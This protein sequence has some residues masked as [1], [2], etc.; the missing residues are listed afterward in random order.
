[1]LVGSITFTQFLADL[2][3]VAGRHLAV[4]HHA[5]ERRAHLGALQLLAREHDAGLGAPRG[6]SARCC[7]APRR[8]RAAWAEV[9]PEPRSVFRRSNWRSACS[10]ACAG[11]AAGRLGR[12]QRCRGWRCRPAAPA[13]RRGARRRRSPQHLQHHGRDLG[14]QVGAPLGL[15]RA[16]DDRAGGERAAA[17]RDDVLGGEEQRL[18]TAVRS[19]IFRSGAC[20]RAISFVVMFDPDMMM[21][22][23]GG[24][25]SQR[26]PSV[27]GYRHNYIAPP[28][29]YSIVE[30]D[31]GPGS[32]LAPVL[33]EAKREI[34]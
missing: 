2:R 23:F 4:A 8:P 20:W 24:C 34:G 32:D 1:M 13:G 7:G 30:P 9:M 6:R 31:A 19:S 28:K 12:G 10:K 14:A 11:G 29:T 21:S 25:S 3:G 26:S 17:D 16:G 5:V 15:D 22:V 27:S 33:A 18:A